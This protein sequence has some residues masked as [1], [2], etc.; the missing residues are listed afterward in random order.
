MKRFLLWLCLTA[1][2]FAAT[3]VQDSDFDGVDDAHDRCP[4]TEFA[5]TVSADGCPVDPPQTPTAVLVGIGG[6]YATGSYGGSDTIDSLSTELSATLY[7]GNFYLSVLGAYYFKGAYDPTV[8]NS[9][10]GG[11]SDTFIGAG[12]TF[13]PAPNIFLTP[14]LLVKLATADDGLGTGENDYGASLQALYRYGH[15][16]LFALYGYT[17]TG[18][19]AAVQYQNISYGSLGAGFTAK[20]GSYVSLSYDMSQPYD[21]SL[22]DL[23]S[24][25]LF[26]IFPLYDTLS[27]RINYS[28]GLSETAS[29]HL[30]STM[31]LIRF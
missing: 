14:G 3:A 28:L 5:L 20:N 27:L 25:S 9:S 19:S 11:I 22:P 26:G 29:D 6:T 16:D 7:R 15:V 13:N 17:V 21:P 24:L 23:E 18:D 12:Y 31:L 8:A 1:S 10:G 30:F 4:G 2:V